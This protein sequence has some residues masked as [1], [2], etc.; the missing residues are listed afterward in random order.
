LRTRA[1][2]E[3][4]IGVFTTRRYTNTRLPYLYLTVRNSNDRA[5]STHFTSL[6]IFESSQITYS[7]L[8]CYI[9][10]QKN[11]RDQFKADDKK[12]KRDKS[13]MA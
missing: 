1:I 3:R 8:T 13:K 11:K 10:L 9:V 6:F 12:M 7:I 5:K 2:P 4:L